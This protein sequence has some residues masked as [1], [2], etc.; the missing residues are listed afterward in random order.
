MGPGGKG[1]LF[2]KLF[3]H[4]GGVSGGH[5]VGRNA[6]HHHGAGTDVCEAFSKGGYCAAGAACAKR[7]EL[8]C[9]LA[10]AG[11]GPCPLG[12]LCKLRRPRPKPEPSDADAPPPDAKPPPVVWSNSPSTR[13]QFPSA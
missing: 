7:H 4:P 12:E 10:A 3:N 2:V 1:L 13:P 11:G 5:A 9:E 8:T 6:V